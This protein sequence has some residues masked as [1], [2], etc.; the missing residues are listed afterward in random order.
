MSPTDDRSAR[1]TASVEARLARF[2]D[3]QGLGQE[4]R[5]GPELIEAFCLC[6]LVGTTPST[7][8]TYR[9]VL[10]Q[11]PGAVRSPRATAL[12]RLGRPGPLR[13]T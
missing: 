4:P 2:V 12:L 13:H 6:G 3:N 11:N 9:S 7:K 5:I 1:R 10:R 8:G